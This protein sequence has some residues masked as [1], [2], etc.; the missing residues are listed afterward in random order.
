MR[1]DHRLTN[2]AIWIECYD[3]ATEPVAYIK[4]MADHNNVL[5]SASTYVNWSYRGRKLAT[6]MYMYAHDLGYQ[7]KPSSLQT[8][9]GKL[10]WKQFRKARL[11]FVKPT[12]WDRV[13]KMFESNSDIGFC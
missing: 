2:D 6:Q 3:R 5:W 13:K 9:E 12:L 7:I 4:F 1:I 8:P 10:M 11:P